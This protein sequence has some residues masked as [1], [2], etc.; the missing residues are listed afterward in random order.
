MN[1]LKVLDLKGNEIEQ[2]KLNYFN[3]R[4]NNFL[5][6]FKLLNILFFN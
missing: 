4:F 1:K 5:F 3:L 2:G 6:D